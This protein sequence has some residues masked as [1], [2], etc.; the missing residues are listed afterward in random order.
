MK[1][2]LLTFL[3]L[4]AIFC[5]APAQICDGNLGENIF[6]EGDFGSGPA[7]VLLPNPQIAPGYN[8]QTN[9]PPDDGYYTITNNTSQW[10]SF[11]SNW[12]DIADNSSDP[13]GYMMVVNASYTPGLFYEQEVEGL[14]ENTLYVFSV[15]VYNLMLA[16]GI[17]PN[18]SFL[19]DG[20]VVYQTGDISNNQKWNTYGF[21]FTTSPGQTSITLAL[22]NNAPGGI[23]NDLALDNITFRPCGPE[24]LIL[25][26][27]IANICEDGSPIQLEATVVGSQYNTP[28]FQWQQSFDEGMTWVDIAGETGMTYTHTDLSGGFYY[29]RYLLANDPSNLLN[30]KCRVVSNIK[31]VNVVPKFYTIVDTLC[32]G[33]AFSLGNNLYSNTGI[34]VDSLLTSI[35]CDSIVTLDLTIVPAGN[36]E[37]AFN[38]SDP[39]CSDLLDGSIQ[40]DTIINGTGPYLI[41]INEELAPNP[42]SLFNLGEA[43]YTYRIIDHF[44]CSFE[45][46][47]SLQTPNPFTIELGDDWQIN[48]GESISLN[49]FFSEPADNYLWSPADLI[50]CDLDCETLDFTPTQSALYSLTATSLSG[51]L[52][53]D[54]IFVEVATVRLVYIPNSFSPNFDGI[55][56]FFT[57]YGAI[58]NV[59]Q[60]EE[61]IIF[62]RWGGVVFEQKGFLPNDESAGWDGTKRKKSLDTGTYAY[63]AKIRFLD[64]VVVLYE[65]DVILIK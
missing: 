19:L 30:S 42:G 13:N 40:I 4:S 18:I 16:N 29:Y 34:Y 64:Q 47:I 23:G 51:C 14:C 52:A 57:I 28:N 21:T 41:Y 39:N 35:G 22:Q 53:T 37:A 25:P 58:P 46:T 38:I 17:R 33:L 65:G 8:Y 31:I 62:D 27:D 20:L 63:L 43:T 45:E 44:R 7:N 3:L 11:A 61:L 55:N 5:L 12:A 32:Q 9:P 26:T 49:P 15:D 2:T 48:L 1:K 10:G 59:Q 50:D 24:A 6:T 54:S 60:I 56:D 36:L